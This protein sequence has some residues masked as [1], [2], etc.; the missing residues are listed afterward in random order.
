M[1]MSTRPPLS[2]DRFAPDPDAPE[3]GSV[4]QLLVRVDPAR[5]ETLCGH[6]Y[7]RLYLDRRIHS[8]PVVDATG[9]PVGLVNRDRFMECFE[10]R[11]AREVPPERPILEYLRVAPLVVDD[12]TT[13]DE[14]AELLVEEGG[15]HIHD[16][17]VITR[18]GVY[19][20]VGT[21]YSLVGALT[22]RRQRQRHHA[23]YHDEV[24]GLAN[25]QLFEDR[26]AFA[27]ASGERSRARVGVLHVEMERLS[28]LTD[29]QRHPAS[30]E[31]L[32]QLGARLRDVVRKG[33]T[34][35]RLSADAFGIILPSIPHV[36]GARTVARKVVGALE[37]PL[38]VGGQQLALASSVGVSVF[39]EDGTSVSRLMRCAERA[40]AHARQMRYA[41]LWCG[42]GG[43]ALADESVCSYG[44]L[45]EAIEQRQLT[46][47]YQPQVDL[48]TGRICGVE[49]LVRWPQAGGAS[50]PA[51]D[52]IAVAESSGLMVP[53][54]EW[55]LRTACQQ[56]R[57]WHEAGVF[58][59]RMAV[60]VSGVQLRQHALP[61]IVQRTLRETGVPPAALELEL[62]EDVVMEASPATTGALEAL[63]ALGVRIS[64]DGFGAGL[65]SVAR[66]ASLPVDSLKL[67]RAFIAALGERPRAEVVARTV[68]AM[69]RAMRLKVIAEGVETAEQLRWLRSQ[70]C[71]VMQGFYVS[72]PVDPNTLAE[73]VR[74]G[75]QL[76]AGLPTSPGW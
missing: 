47:V 34:V 35:A 71:D 10:G 4:R 48:A 42:P 20:G 54:A 40:A 21:G 18:G 76:P 37:A 29:D 53:L 30:E 36:E 3:D 25:L 5:P 23:T 52:I 11:G 45:R 50:V 61:A 46:L 17:F 60:N 8:L 55:V 44:S 67:D 39:P 66:L 65:S 12:E 74:S 38:D 2:P 56:M 26:L 68:M 62:A 7:D 9:R 1:T 41:Y 51:N 58:V 73:L 57:A 43:E 70:G 64:V 6:V 27:L 32:K 69:A 28:A 72:R 19:A 63:K 24:T 33:D 31:W 16:G 59:V 13:L 75:P 49:A 15:A 14:V 22:R